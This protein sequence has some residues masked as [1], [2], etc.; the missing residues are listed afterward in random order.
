MT[1]DARPRTAAP[2]CSLS[3]LGCAAALSWA[4][5]GSAAVPRA[6]DPADPSDAAI[7][8]AAGDVVDAGHVRNGCG[9]E[10][11]PVVSHPVPGVAVLIEVDP[12]GAC[13]GSNRPSS[14]SVLV[15]G[16]GG[17]RLSTS[18]TGSGYRVGQVGSAM[19]TIVVEYP[20]SQVDCPVL[21]WGDGRY[22]MTRPCRPLGS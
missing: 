2:R 16:P 18:T 8:R 11:R 13:S 21:T 17:W 10:V 5:A 7:L 9:V 15:R 6:A 12:T 19:P 3:V 14:L 20:P 4:P 1:R 22:S